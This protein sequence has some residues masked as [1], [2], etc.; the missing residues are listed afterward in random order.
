MKFLVYIWKRFLDW[1][2]GILSR[3]IRPS[4]QVFAA[5]VIFNHD[6]QILLER[7]TYQ[8]IHPWGLPGGNLNYGEE[9]EDAVIRE[10]KEEIGFD[11]EVR[12]LLLA[13]NANA[14]HIFGLFYWCEIVG[15]QF[16]PTFEVSEIKYFAID[17]LPDVRPS[18][19]VLL[20]QLS[21]KVDVLKNE[22]A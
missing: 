21:E 10:V 1:L 19:L 15:G 8:E 17:D 2:Q 22:L 5:A 20:K 11:V 7:L 4:F 13:K 3:I 9:P 6:Q 18:D 12:K 14:K 16:K